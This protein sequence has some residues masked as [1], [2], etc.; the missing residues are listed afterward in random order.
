MLSGSWRD[1]STCLEGSAGP[2]R[3]CHPSDTCYFVLISF[4]VGSPIPPIVSE[5]PATGL[6]AV[7]G[8]PLALSYRCY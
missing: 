2:G 3:L 4:E 5:A 8:V 1:A 6:S 7:A